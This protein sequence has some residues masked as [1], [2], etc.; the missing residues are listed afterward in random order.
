ML[1]YEHYL[2]LMSYIKSNQ[3][4]RHFGIWLDMG[5]SP[6]HIYQANQGDIRELRVSC[7]M[8][9][10]ILSKFRLLYT[11]EWSISEGTWDKMGV[12]FLAVFVG[13]E[14]CVWKS[15]D[16]RSRVVQ[17]R[18]VRV[19]QKTRSSLVRFIEYKRSKTR[20]GAPSVFPRTRIASLNSAGNVVIQFHT[21]A[22][23]GIAIAICD[24][25]FMLTS[26]EDKS[27]KLCSTSIQW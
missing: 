18:I 20:S 5:G 22:R 24:S 8:L 14:N 15:E 27:R 12:T 2:D 11:V 13:P 3:S 4:Q 19:G 17:L 9:K 26:N 25:R 7:R 23:R 6:T 16:S 1:R 21:A 10:N